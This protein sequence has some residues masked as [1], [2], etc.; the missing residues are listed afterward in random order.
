MT[1]SRSLAQALALWGAVMGLGW[2]GAPP[3]GL[4]AEVLERALAVYACA[5]EKGQGRAGQLTVIDFSLPSTARRLWVLDLER[6]EVLFNEWV[7][8]GQGSGGNR[9]TEFSNTSGSHQSSLGLYQAAETY[10]GRHGYSLRLDGLEDSNDRARSR[11]I[12][13]H[14]ADY[15]TEAFMEEH[16]RMGRSHGCPAV[17]PDISRPLIDALRDGGLVWAWYPDPAWTESSPYLSCE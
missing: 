9:S 7:S 2:Q 4:R 15:V 5:R 8:H 16:G 1:G 11:A 14:A 12:V 6:E 17:R 13:I 3:P 10:Q